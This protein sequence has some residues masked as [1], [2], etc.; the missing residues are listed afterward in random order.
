MLAGFTPLL[1]L[2]MFEHAHHMDYGA[3]AAAY[4]D[5]SMKAIKWP[6]AEARFAE[7]R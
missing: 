2:D 4:V 1:A 5:A 3:A 7:L 6:S